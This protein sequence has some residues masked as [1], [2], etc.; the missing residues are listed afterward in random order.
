LT[1]A[2]RPIPGQE[3]KLRKADPALF[4]SFNV[5]KPVRLFDGEERPDDRPSTLKPRPR[6][7]LF[8]DCQT[9]TLVLRLRGGKTY[10]PILPAWR[11]DGL[12]RVRGRLLASP[13]YADAGGR[14][15]IWGEYP[16]EWAAIESAHGPWELRSAAELALNGANISGCNIPGA[17]ELA[18]RT[19]EASRMASRAAESFGPLAHD[20]QA[21]QRVP[22][23]GRREA[24]ELYRLELEAAEVKAAAGRGRV[25][26]SEYVNATSGAYGAEA[27]M[28][29]DGRLFVGKN[30]PALDRSWVVAVG[31]IGDYSTRRLVKS[32]NGSTRKV[33]AQIA[34]TGR[35]KPGPKPIGAT[36]MTSAERQRRRRNKLRIIA[37][38]PSHI[39][40]GDTNVRNV[41]ATQSHLGPLD[42]GG[43]DRA[44]SPAAE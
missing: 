14:A 16:R 30:G 41:N 39:R 8:L 13:R 40:S 19:A 33:E 15:L 22:P 43:E 5:T 23:W 34:A 6:A 37:E 29:P 24:H 21:E 32:K 4:D 9:G 18:A 25:M 1:N 36:A 28:A 7:R 10:V 27:R 17:V 26:T 3:P 31:G 35:S 2:P 42:R 12:A 38:I 11:A 20:N 44:D